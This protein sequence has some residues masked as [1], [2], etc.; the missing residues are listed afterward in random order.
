M[1][2]RIL[3]VDDDLA[4]LMMLTAI[5]EM[6]GFESSSPLPPRLKLR[7]GPETSDL[8]ITDL[9]MEHESPV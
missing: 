5:L 8:V 9:K 4:I 3:L 7:L 6:K 1:T 2:R